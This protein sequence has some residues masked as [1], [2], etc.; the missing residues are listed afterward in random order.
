MKKFITLLI[1][2]FLFLSCRNVQKDFDSTYTVTYNIYYP[3]NTVTN[4]YTFDGVKGEVSVEVYAYRGCNRLHVRYCNPSM[5]K[6]G[7]IGKDI[8]SSTAP[9][10]IISVERIR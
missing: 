8:E 10:Q 7:E 5:W 3:G 1:F 4:E 9:I 6:T 2:S